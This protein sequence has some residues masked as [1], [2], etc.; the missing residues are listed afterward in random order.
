M[1]S[2]S[3]REARNAA[4]ARPR[5]I[6]AL[7]GSLGAGTGS[8]AYQRPSFGMSRS[9]PHSYDPDAD[10]DEDDDPEPY[11]P[12]TPSDYVRD[13]HRELRCASMLLTLPD[14]QTDEDDGGD[15]DDLRDTP[16]PAKPGSQ[17]YF[18][19]LAVPSRVTADPVE[20]KR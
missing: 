20:P 2:R 12:M 15:G 14:S 8:T 17:S 18:D 10:Y 13:A 19:D 9:A 4:Q 1:P 5:D 11:H 6:D 16:K 3:Y 7:T